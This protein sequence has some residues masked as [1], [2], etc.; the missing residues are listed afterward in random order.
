[1]TFSHRLQRIA[2]L[3]TSEYE[4]IWDTCCDHGQLGAALLDQQA[5]PWIH[6]VD[7]VP[8]VMVELESRLQ[9]LYPQ[10]QFDQSLFEQN[11]PIGFGSAWQIHCRDVASL[12]LREYSGTHLVVV[13]GVGG[14]RM[15]TFVREIVAANPTTQIDFL[16][17]PVQRQF[18]LRQQLIKLNLKLKAELLIAEKQRCY[19]VMLVSFTQSELGS[20][21]AVSSVGD[22]IWRAESVE[23]ARIVKQY[24]RDSLD[25]YQAKLDGSD[26]NFSRTVDA[27]R[28][29]ECT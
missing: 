12:A 15:S 16:L 21:P 1:M 23:Q 29:I 4:H 14:E 10:V 8:S 7:V 28:A 20:S 13:A 24:L 27:Y 17:C 9:R 5:A 19:E 11:F 3:I 22:S 26:I 6:F 25:Y 2:S 18:A